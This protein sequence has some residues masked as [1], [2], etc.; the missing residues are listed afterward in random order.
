MRHETSTVVYTVHVRTEMRLRDFTLCTPNCVCSPS[1]PWRCTHYGEDYVMNVFASKLMLPDRAFICVIFTKPREYA[2]FLQEFLRLM[3][4]RPDPNNIRCTNRV[5]KFFF[6]HGNVLLEDMHADMVRTGATSTRVARRRAPPP[7][8]VKKMPAYARAALAA[9]Y[10]SDDSDLTRPPGG[11]QEQELELLPEP[12]VTLN[13]QRFCAL[14][15]KPFREPSHITIEVFSS[16]VLNVAGITSDA[17][18]D[19]VRRYIMTTIRPL[20][21]RHAVA[22]ECLAKP[23]SSFCLPPVTS[24]ATRRSRLRERLRPSSRK[25]RSCD[26]TR[27]LACGT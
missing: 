21:Q 17:G 19:S 23:G 18:F 15:I 25:R 16:G 1:T 20:L 2:W 27:M 26:S 9:T 7:S 10:D 22:T 4:T 8:R 6:P 13:L 24:R 5:E 3:N 14:I 12:L 11:A